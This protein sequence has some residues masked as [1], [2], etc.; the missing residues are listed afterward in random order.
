MDSTHPDGFAPI[1]DSYEYEDSFA[2]IMTIGDI[3][4]NA[5][6]C[7]ISRRANNDVHAAAAFTTQQ[8][9]TTHPTSSNRC[10]QVSERY[11]SSLR[12]YVG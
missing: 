1:S 3:A 10:S 9:V 8:S 4:A 11:A 12:F 6:S 5:A 2:H 7:V